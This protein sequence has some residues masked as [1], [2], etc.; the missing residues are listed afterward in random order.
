MRYLR[1]QDGKNIKMTYRL[2]II[3]CILWI[4]IGCENRIV[5]VQSEIVAASDFRVLTY[6]IHHANPP[7][8]PNVIDIDAIANVIKQQQP[9]L[10]ALQEVDVYTN[11]SGKTLNETSEIARLAGLPYYFFGKAIDYQGGEYGVAILSKYPLSSMAN[12]PLPTAAGSG[13]ELRTLATAIISLPGNKTIVFA[14]THLDAQT[15]ETNRLLQ[16]QKI[17]DILNPQTIPVILAGDFNAIPGSNTIN[18]LDG[19]FTRSCISSCGF[20]ISAI[21][22]TKTIDFIAYRPSDKFTVTS[23]KVIEE[24]YASDHLPVLVVFKIN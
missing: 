5:P 3:Y 10:I 14:S 15:S 23:H 18:I 22:P 16:I 13:G 7:S 1:I 6:N 11:R 9:D 4:A 24:K 21:S 12:Y 20:T 19:N 8:K 17:T 2:I